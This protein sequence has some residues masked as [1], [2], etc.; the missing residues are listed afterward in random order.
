MD[1]DCD[2]QNKSKQPKLRGLHFR[3]P[4]LADAQLDD[5]G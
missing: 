4:A 5:L 2:I 1:S 3:L